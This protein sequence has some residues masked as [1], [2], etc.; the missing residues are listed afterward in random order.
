MSSLRHINPRGCCETHT[1][2]AEMDIQCTLLRRSSQRI[3]SQSYINRDMCIILP[4]CFTSMRLL[5]RISTCHFPLVF[6]EHTS[7][8]FS[9]S[10]SFFFFYVCK[11]N[12]SL[13]TFFSWSQKLTQKHTSFDFF[14]VQ[15]MI[16]AQRFGRR[17][18]FLSQATN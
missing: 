6:Y 8:S 13:Y 5:L 16:T 1:V 12:Y 2:S 14:P 17:L 10:L 3:S 9:L 15:W 4:R 18:C 11:E 7:Y